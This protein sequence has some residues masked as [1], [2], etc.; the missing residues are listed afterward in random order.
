MA[1]VQTENGF[2]TLAD[3]LMDALMRV[4]LSGR[5]HAL[6]L[7]V[8]RKTY[9]WNKKSDTIASSQ[10]EEMTG[11]PA[12]K[13]REIVQAL[14]DKGLLLLSERKSDQHPWTISINKDYSTWNVPVRKGRPSRGAKTRPLQGAHNKD[15][16]RSSKKGEQLALVGG[17][18]SRP[19]PTRL[20]D[21][22]VD[23]MLAIRPRGQTYTR[24]EF[25]AWFERIEPLM[26]A[27]GK[28]STRRAA[29][30]W[31]KNVTRKEVANSVKEVALIKVAALEPA[32]E[33]RDE[34]S[35]EDFAEA[36]GL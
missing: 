24:E 27:D 29:P 6:L 30:R 19:L 21:A 8:M 20:D 15:I 33:A 7:A 2:T 22:F 31:W 34:D 10:F 26:I 1:D 11:I 25:R 17:E 32:S 5:E 12:N 4:K 16:D 13:A 36:F 14:A 18:S 9:G 23:K 35:F 3:E 28:K